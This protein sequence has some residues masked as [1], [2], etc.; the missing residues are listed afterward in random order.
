MNEKEA[1]QLT[2][3]FFEGDTTL[4]DEERLYAYY[5][6]EQVAP[7][8]MADRQMF[9]DMCCLQGCEPARK[10]QTLPLTPHRHLALRWRHIAIAATVAAMA[11][12]VTAVW[13][14]PADDCEM[15]AYGQRLTD[16]EAV[17]HEVESTLT[18]AQSATP[19]VG[20]E[21]RDAFGQYDDTH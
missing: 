11:G 13:L 6:S 15:V 12:I 5:T 19:D 20:N 2:D 10:S 18:D 4:A 17:M 16:R 3:R 1:R 21:L 9:L 8:L 7:A 14:R